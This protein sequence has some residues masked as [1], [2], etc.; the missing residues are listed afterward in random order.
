MSIII[1][2]AFG[3]SG[4]IDPMSFVGIPEVLRIQDRPTC[5][6]LGATLPVR[7]L[8]FTKNSPGLRS[9]GM[10]ARLKIAAENE[11]ML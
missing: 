2:Q 11:K 7:V 1:R 5:H 8:P 10:I 4:V 3:P 9:N 6:C